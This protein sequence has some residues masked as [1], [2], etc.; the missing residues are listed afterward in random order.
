MP[1]PRLTRE[2]YFRYWL[3]PVLDF[4]GTLEYWDVH[5]PEDEHGEGDPAAEGFGT[6]QA[7]KDW[8]KQRVKEDRWIHSLDRMMIKR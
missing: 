5:D 4:D 7:A 2:Q 1:Q 8:V 6:K 3:W